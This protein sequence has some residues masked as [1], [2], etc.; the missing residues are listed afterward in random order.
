MRRIA[1]VLAFLTTAAVGSA[2][3]PK[4]APTFEP[5]DTEG[6][7]VSPNPRIRH[8]WKRKVFWEGQPRARPRHVQAHPPAH[9]R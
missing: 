3:Y 7:V 1:L 4:Q 8:A 9:R 5:G 2:Q 6:L